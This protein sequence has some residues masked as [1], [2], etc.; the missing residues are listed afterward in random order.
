MK[1]TKHWLKTWGGGREEWEY[2]G[3]GELVQSTLCACRNYH[4]KT[5][6]IINVY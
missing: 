4:N 3:G 2:N 5:P 6:H 1:P